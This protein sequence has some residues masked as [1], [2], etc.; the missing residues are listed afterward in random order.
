MNCFNH[1]DKAAVGTCKACHKGICPD[2]AADLGFGLACRGVHEQRV[3]EVE[4]LI[5]RNARIQTT[6]GSVRYLNP[7]FLLFMG[8][9]FAGYGLMN[10]RGSKF[11]VLLGVGFF[12]YG[13]YA[14]LA[15]LKAFAKTESNK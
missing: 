13:V 1:P 8:A 12:V 14:F 10:G 5:S 11:L 3:T 4:E 6:A 9:V 15:N 2:C 7:L